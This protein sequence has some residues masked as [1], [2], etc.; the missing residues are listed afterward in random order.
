MNSWLGSFD[1]FVKKNEEWEH[2]T[3]IQNT[4]VDSGLNFLREVLRGAITDGEIKYIAVGT[5]TA[6]VS[7]SQTQLGAELFRKQIYSK[8]ATGTG[9][10]QSIAIFEDNEAI[11]Q[12]REIG[13]FAGTTASSVS[14]TGIMI[15]R[16]LYSKDK[17]SLESLQIQRTDTI[18]RS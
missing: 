4:I 2:E 11:G 18:T 8:T 6:S 5:S 16:V 10:L 15:S 1:I 9:Q 14:N 7:T 13:V 3:T 12:I 17:T